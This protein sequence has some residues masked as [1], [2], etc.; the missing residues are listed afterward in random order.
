MNREGI[1]LTLSVKEMT[2]T[3]KHASMI[4]IMRKIWLIWLVGFLVAMALAPSVQIHALDVTTSQFLEPWGRR[5]PVLQLIWVVGG[6]PLTTLIVL[7]V[8][9]GQF[10][11]ETAHWWILG[12]F[13]LG[14]VIEVVAKHFVATAFPP[15]VPPSGDLKRLIIWTNIEPSTVVG[16]IRQ[17]HSGPASVRL[18]SSHLF[19]GSFPSGHVFRITYAYGLFLSP[20]FRIIAATIAA[21][22]VVA[23][24][25]HWIWDAVGGYLLASLC[26]EWAEFLPRKGQVLTHD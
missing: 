5:Y 16:W 24:G 26:L 4:T 20:K 8:A 21:I 2:A 19:N 7:Y 12:F 15:N 25:G 11:K 9:S 18:V 22:S 17:I 3:A 10:G 1:I 14:S 13:V 6:I 23:T